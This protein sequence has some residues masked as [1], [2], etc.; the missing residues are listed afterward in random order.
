[1]NQLEADGP[2]NSNNHHRY[3]FGIESDLKNSLFH[4]DGDQII[5][6]V[7]AHVVMARLETREM[8]FFGAGDNS[9]TK[10]RSVTALALSANKKLLAV[11]QKIDDGSCQVRH[12]HIYLVC[13]KPTP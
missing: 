8:M 5:Y 7:G 4:V 2:S 1:M 11:S 13:T 6:P 3:A 12:H 9:T 10:V